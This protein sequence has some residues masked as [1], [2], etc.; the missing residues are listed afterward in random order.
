MFRSTT[1]RGLAAGL[2]LLTAAACG[3]TS[4]G[5][6]SSSSGNPAAPSAPALNLAGAWSGTL[7]SQ[8]SNGG[9]D[10]NPNQ[11]KWTATQSGSNV[12]GPLVV[13]ASEEHS[14]TTET[15]IF[16]G[17]LAGAITGSD[18]TL[19]LTMPPGVFADAPTCSI[20][21]TGTATPTASKITSTM[22]VTF[23]SSCVGTVTDKAT[24]TDFL[25]LTK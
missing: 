6:S 15:M 19:T 22:T 5:G 21:G 25:T 18:M 8:Q 9:T 20:S 14:G 1:L 13:T 7:A 23:S 2:C 4:S 17:T 3:S 10:Q 11:L 12:T 16:N 24:E